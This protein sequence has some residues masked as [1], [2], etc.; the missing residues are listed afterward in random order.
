M[1][2]SQEWSTAR[3]GV[4]FTKEDDECEK[5]GWLLLF[6]SFVIRSKEDR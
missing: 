2:F 4:I 1:C 5:N 3:T 6:L